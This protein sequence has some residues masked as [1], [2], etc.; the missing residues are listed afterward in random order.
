MDLKM[1]GKIALV[2]GAGSPIGFGREISIQLAR[3]GCDVAV[4]DLNLE[5]AEGT[6]ELVRKEGRKS[7]AIKADVTKKAEVREMVRKT[8]DEFGRI[9][10]LINNAGAVL[11]HGAFVDQTEEDWDRDFDL[12]LKGTM[13]VAQ[14]VL[15]SMLERK[16]GKIV[17]ISSGSSKV[18]HPGVSAYTIAKAGVMAFTR[19]LAKQVITDGINVNSVAPG[20]S[21]TNFIKGDKEKMKAFF[22]PETPIG[23]GTE[24]EDIAAMT[25]FLCSDIAGDI[26]GQVFSVDGGSTMQ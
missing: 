8:L 21:L 23:R 13:L 10:I 24:P 3:E 17:N 18:V 6:A 2:T 4:N 1:K 25:V 9:D 12:N 15:P 22:L 16:Y 19:G 5:D 7:I 11:S 26:V 20:W 14:A